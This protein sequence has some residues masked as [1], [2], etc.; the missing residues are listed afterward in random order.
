MAAPAQ[1]PLDLTVDLGPMP[2]DEQSGGV[3]RGL[4]ALVDA[5][6]LCDVVFVADGHSFPAHQAVLAAATSSFQL[7]FQRAAAARVE[8][9]TAAVAAPDGGSEGASPTAGTGE[10]A[11]AAQAPP[12]AIAVLDKSSALEVCLDDIT[13]SEAVRAMLDCV[14]GAVGGKEYSP[15]SEDANR[16]VLRLAQQFQLI[17]LQDQ[18]S[19]WLLKSI[20]TSNALD[21]LK[22]CEEFGLGDVKE[23]ILEQLV[24]NPDALLAL[25]ND[26][27]I[28]KVPL[29]LQKLLIRIL[30]LLGVA[31]P[32]PPQQQAPAPALAPPQQTPQARQAAPAPAPVPAAPQQKAQVA[33]LGTKGTRPRVAAVLGA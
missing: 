12:V 4:R 11:A 18:A 17:P 29:V 16:D 20:S 23:R 26:A 27:E 13:H 21:R 24:A 32:A 3:M 2:A 25:A 15:S 19:R 33:K 6:E 9:A 22:A 8:A 14:Y 28:V 30:K 10:E 31:E 7:C 1:P 5:G